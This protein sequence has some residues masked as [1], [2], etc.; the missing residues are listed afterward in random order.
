MSVH[1]ACLPA[2]VYRWAPVLLAKR[3]P[4][5]NLLKFHTSIIELV[6]ISTVFEREADERLTP[7]A[8][9]GISK[10]QPALN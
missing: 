2:K 3:L 5:A 7:Y 10:N 1:T 8:N 9:V 6:Q 4:R